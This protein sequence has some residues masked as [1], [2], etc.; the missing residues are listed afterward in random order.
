MKK[1]KLE[2]L[3]KEDLPEDL[4]KMNFEELK[5]HLEAKAS[6]RAE[7]QAKIQKLS[8]ARSKYVAKVRKKESE[9]GEETLETAV[10]KNLRR[11]AE[12]RGFEFGS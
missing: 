1:I 6:S 7:I 4:R 11:Q 9:S 5:A 3:K 12:S 10:I 8:V 2:E